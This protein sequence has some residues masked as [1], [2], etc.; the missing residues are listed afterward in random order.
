MLSRGLREP[1]Y[2][3]YV[4]VIYR[5][6]GEIGRYQSNELSREEL[7]TLFVRYDDF[8]DSDGRHSI[9]LR[10]EQDDATLVYDRHNL[11]YAYGPLERFE[12]ILESVGYAK[13]P[14]VSLAFEHEHC[15]YPEFDVFEQEL[16]TKYAERKTDLQRGD[17]NPS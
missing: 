6:G 17:E 8:W 5:G 10:S 1:F 13:T 9:W 11:I 7:D 12:L 14:E 2:F 4:L 15:Y 16:T 3:L